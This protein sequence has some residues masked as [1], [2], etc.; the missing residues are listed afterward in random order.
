VFLALL[1][2][3]RAAAFSDPLA[4]PDAVDVGGGGGR[5]FTGS[6]AD[7]YGCDVCHSGGAAADLDV[8]G[9]PLDGFAPGQPYEITVSWPV[10][11][12]TL[13]LVAEFTDEVRQGAGVL[14]LPREDALQPDESCALEEG[15]GPGTA[16]HEA[17]SQRI[18]LSLVDCGVRRV[19]FQ[20]TAPATAPETPIWFNLGLVV[21]NVDA[22]PLGDGVTLVRR[23][24][25]AVGG[26]LGT[27]TVAQGCSSAPN[28][29]HE[30]FLFTFGTAV[31]F[32]SSSRTRLRR[33]R[34]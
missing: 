19:R 2:P 30:S 34:P 7:G 25:V 13:T 5:W 6:S 12:E 11:V 20:W 10:E 21:S 23:P 14:A 17:E 28:A 29:S 8:R 26:A 1:L 3:E 16:L 32:A 18:L 22:T 9:L 33:R 15:G 24:F 27:R 4:Y 31:S